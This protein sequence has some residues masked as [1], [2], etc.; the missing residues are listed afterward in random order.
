MQPVR[1]SSKVKRGH[2]Q[3]YT[4][5]NGNGARRYWINDTILCGGSILNHQDY[6]HL[7]TNLGV[8]GVMNFCNTTKDPDGI[9]H[10]IHL[11]FP[12]TG[13]AIPHSLIHTALAFAKRHIER[14]GPVLYVHCALGGS[15]GPSMSY[16]VCRG[17]L[18]MEPQEIFD[19]IAA[20]HPLYLQWKET[21][22]PKQYLKDI[23]EALLTWVG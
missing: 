13:A 19:A 10:Y 3:F 1:I 14:V 23:E 2:V 17:V 4:D 6:Q 20:G 12:D 9:E 7:R 18:G 15:R 22:N 8:T 21:G 16:A 11:P 5:K